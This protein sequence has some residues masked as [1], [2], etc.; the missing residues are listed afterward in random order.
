MQGISLVTLFLE[1]GV[2]TTSFQHHDTPSRKKQLSVDTTIYIDHSFL[3]MPPPQEETVQSL[4]KND[5]VTCCF[6]SFWW[7]TLIEMVNSA[8]KDYLCTFLHP[9][10]P[11]TQFHWPRGNDN[12]YVPVTKIIMKI[13]IP[14]TSV[15]GR[16][17]YI[18][19]DERKKHRTA[20][21]LWINHTSE[22]KFLI[23]HARKGF[24]NRP[25]GGPKWFI[26]HCVNGLSLKG[27]Y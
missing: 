7:V 9:H 3:D 24:G 17:Y 1:V 2:H 19:E 27:G 18:T 14:T 5:Y 23:F 11:S 26:L 12:G 25:L 21:R 8:E 16:T 22:T 10:G 13:G 20:L 15:N 4:Q 6:D